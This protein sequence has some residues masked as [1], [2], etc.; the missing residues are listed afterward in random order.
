MSKLA[1]ITGGIRGIGAAI[2][3][4]LK[5]NGYEVI[6]NYEQN[7]QLAEEFS[8]KYDIKV[9]P[10]NVAD[11]EECKKNIAAIEKD[12]GKHVSVLINNAGIIRDSMMHKMD[13]LHW[14]QLI[15]INLSSCFNMSK[16]VIDNMR[17]NN[18]GRIISISSINAQAGQIGQ[19]NYSAA[20]A[21]IIGFTKALARE[22]AP[23]GITVNCVAP[24][25]I[26]TDMTKNVPSAILETIINATP[27]K[28]LGH[29]EEVARAVLFLIDEKSGFITGETLS[30]NG[31]YHMS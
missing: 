24:G 29:P 31:G 16:A 21:G 17:N 12:A 6:A 23:K 14:R 19:T 9:R 25:Y 30:I 27:V 7:H 20:K 10:W 13:I 1:V 26:E 2:S 5:E 3:V 18:F 22:S 4:A 11:F 28:R 15:D 8:K